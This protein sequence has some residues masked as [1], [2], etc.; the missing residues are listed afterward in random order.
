MCNVYVKFLVI[1]L[2]DQYITYRTAMS[3]I[4]P[5]G[6][7]QSLYLLTLPQLYEC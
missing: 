3:R 2:T 5:L 4:I 7:E 6:K 1:V